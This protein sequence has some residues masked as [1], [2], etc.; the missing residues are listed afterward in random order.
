MILIMT[1]KE[2][3][4]IITQAAIRWGQ[5]ALAP[6]IR[7]DKEFAKVYRSDARNLKEVARLVR[8]N[9]LVE[10][11]NKASRLDTIVRDIIPEGPWQHMIRSL[12]GEQD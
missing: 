7:K 5:N 6:D 12:N 8:Q 3:A 1:N 9:K 4:S 11:A 10:A 2:A